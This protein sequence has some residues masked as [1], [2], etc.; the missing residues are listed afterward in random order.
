MGDRLSMKPS[1]QDGRANRHEKEK[2][3]YDII[4]SLCHRTACLGEEEEG[5]YIAAGVV[6]PYVHL[7]SSPALCTEGVAYIFAWHQSRQVQVVEWLSTWRYLL[8]L[9]RDGL[10]TR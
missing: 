3:P 7:P 4:S 6:N 1:E 8:S 5:N 10:E 9:S 2:Q